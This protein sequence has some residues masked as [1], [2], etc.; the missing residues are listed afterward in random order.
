[1]GA[2][3]RSIFL[4]IMVKIREVNLRK[5]FPKVCPL[6]CKKYYDWLNYELLLGL[7]L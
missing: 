4:K 3:A 5:K 1:M 7:G 2:G 6:S